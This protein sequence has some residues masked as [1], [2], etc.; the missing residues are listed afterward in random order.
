MGLGSRNFR[1]V[2]PNAPAHQRSN[3]RDQDDKGDL[4]II[5]ANQ[6]AEWCV[7]DRFPA[8]SCDAPLHK[9]GHRKDLQPQDGN[10]QTHLQEEE[11]ISKVKRGALFQPAE[12]ANEAGC[13]P[14]Q[15]AQ[16]PKPVGAE[17]LRE[18]FTVP[19]RAAQLAE[20]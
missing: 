20:P 2:E 8:A 4:E 7:S 11:A 10:E 17:E 5:E 6:N 9:G 1:S 18:R 13:D 19:E 12:C 15:G 3:E 14:Y 16:A